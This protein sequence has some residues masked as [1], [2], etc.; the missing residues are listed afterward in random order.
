VCKP[1]GSKAGLV[2]CCAANRRPALVAE[3]GPC[4]QVRPARGTREAKAGPALQTETRARRILVLAPGTLHLTLTNHVGDGR[5]GET[6]LAPGHSKGNN[7]LDDM[8]S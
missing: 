3:L 1:R 2:G 7:G 6:N 8:V 5:N 4:G